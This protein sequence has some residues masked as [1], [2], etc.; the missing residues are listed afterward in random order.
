M[1]FPTYSPDLNPIENLLSALKSAVA[2]DNPKTEVQLIQSRQN[3]WQTLTT[4]E[5]LSPYFKSLEQRYK[6]CIEK[7]CAII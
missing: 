6:I 7:N 3:N 2:C 4:Q 5:T 1:S